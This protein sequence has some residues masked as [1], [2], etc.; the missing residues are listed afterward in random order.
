MKNIPLISSIMSTKIITLKKD[1]ELETAE[2]LFKR[3]KIRHIPVVEGESIIGMLSY[4]DLL[5]ISFVD[6]VDDDGEIESLVYNMFTIEQVMAK[7]VVSVPST[8]NIKEVAEILAKKEFHALPVVD[9]DVLVGIVTTTDLIN[10][11][12]MRL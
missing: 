10:F 3:H 1:D 11:L 2:R 8:A 7:N 12:I 9:D 5:R 4:T 6:A